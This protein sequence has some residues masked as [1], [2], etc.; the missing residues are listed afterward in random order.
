MEVGDKVVCVSAAMQ[1][2]T[3][4]ELTKDVPN[5]VKKDETYTIREILDHD[6][7]VAVLLEEIVNPIKY[8]KVLDRTMEPAFAIV[9]FRKIETQEAVHEEELEEAH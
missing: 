9:R 8:F 6:F 1:P 4:E 7:V 3:V 5:W 2:H